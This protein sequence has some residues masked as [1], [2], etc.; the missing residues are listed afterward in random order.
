MRRNA[1]DLL[2]QRNHLQIFRAIR[3]VVRPADDDVAADGVAAVVAEVAAFVLKFDEDVLP[4]AADTCT[5]LG[6][7][8]GEGALEVFDGEAETFGV[9]FFYWLIKCPLGPTACLR[10]AR[11]WRSRCR[12]A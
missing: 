12:S 8:I 11:K 5:A 6:E 2:P 9:S 10:L 4:G 7:A 3:P 1:L